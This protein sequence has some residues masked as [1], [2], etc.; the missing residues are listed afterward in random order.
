VVEAAARPRRT[1]MRV[2]RT[3]VRRTR[4]LQGLDQVNGAYHQLLAM[5]ILRSLSMRSGLLLVDTLAQEEEVEELVEDT[6]RVGKYDRT[7]L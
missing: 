5:M 4:F 2:Y 1:H 7:R 6:L 3:T